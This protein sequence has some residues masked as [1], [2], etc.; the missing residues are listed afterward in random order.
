MTFKRRPQ[1]Q[2]NVIQND[3]P[4]TTSQAINPITSRSKIPIVKWVVN[5]QDKT[6]IEVDNVK[7]LNP[8]PLKGE[9]F[10][11]LNKDNL[12]VLQKTIFFKYNA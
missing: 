10:F 5:D 2:Y 9:G 4:A 3:K 7:S 1:V 11:F 6:L 8:S 12:V